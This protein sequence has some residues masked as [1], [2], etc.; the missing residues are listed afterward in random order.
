[1]PPITSLVDDAARFATGADARIS[2]AAMIR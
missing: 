1:L 2:D